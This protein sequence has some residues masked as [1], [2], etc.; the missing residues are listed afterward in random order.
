MSKDPIFPADRSIKLSDDGEDWFYNSDPRARPIA[1]IDDYE[2]YLP[3][4]SKH[5]P[6]PSY[7]PDDVAKPPGYWLMALS[8]LHS[9]T[10]D[11]IAKRLGSALLAQ[12]KV[13]QYNSEALSNNHWISEMERLFST[14]LARVQIDAWSIASGEDYAHVENDGYVDE[15]PNEAGNLCGWFKYNPPGYSHIRL[16]PLILLLLVLPVL[17]LLSLE[18]RKVGSARDYAILAFRKIRLGLSKAWNKISGCTSRRR[19]QGETESDAHIGTEEEES[20]EEQEANPWAGEPTQQVVESIKPEWEPLVVNWLF[21][22]QLQ[23]E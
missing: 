20:D 15:T 17:W 19:N 21:C 22:R 11:S 14:S 2:H 18:S 3:D 4:G 10:Y 9:N 7:I 13:S 16:V 8:L 6:D 1:C 23:T 12:N 5:W